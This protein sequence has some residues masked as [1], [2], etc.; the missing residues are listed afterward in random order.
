MDFLFIYICLDFNYALNDIKIKKQCNAICFHSQQAAEKVLKALLKEIKPSEEI[1]RTHDISFLFE[2]IK[3]N[4]PI[5]EEMR[6][7]G[8]LLTKY[9]SNSRYDFCEKIDE[10]QAETAIIMAK[11]IY[12]W[13]NEKIKEHENLQKKTNTK[14]PKPKLVPKNKDPKT[15]TNNLS[16]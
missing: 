11:K 7:W 3:N 2:E 13:A 4:Y 16:R 1:I 6:K 9:E 8:I 5:D 15:K 10:T 14:T 12:K